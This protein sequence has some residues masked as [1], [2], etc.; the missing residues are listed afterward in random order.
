MGNDLSYV[1]GTPSGCRIC[2]DTSGGYVVSHELSPGQR[3]LTPTLA[4]AYA[5]CQGWE[6]RDPSVPSDANG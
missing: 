5:A 2:R 6:R 1:S 4:G 3:S